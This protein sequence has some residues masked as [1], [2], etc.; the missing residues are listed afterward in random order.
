MGDYVESVVR[1]YKDLA[2]TVGIK[3]QGFDSWAK[4]KL[5]N[6]HI[7]YIPEVKWILVQ[8]NQL[9]EADNPCWHQGTDFPLECPKSMYKQ[10]K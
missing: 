3:I 9:Y 1:S 7:L 8:S 6:K 10:P 5:G 2:Y 4:I